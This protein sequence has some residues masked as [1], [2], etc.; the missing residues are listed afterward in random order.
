MV[1]IDLELVSVE[2]DVTVTMADGV[3]NTE[4]DGFNDM[5]TGYDADAD[6]VSVADTE[7]EVVT[8]AD[9]DGI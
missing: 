7:A 2:S 8:W 6:D 4:I 1:V 9:T 5:L 3:I